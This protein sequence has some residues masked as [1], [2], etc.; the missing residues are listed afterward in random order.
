MGMMYTAGID[1]GSAFSKAVIIAGQEMI[2]SHMIPS[3]GNYGLSAEKVIR[4]A[5]DSA[6]LSRD[7]IRY[8]AATG[9]G[10]RSVPF[11]DRVVSDITCNGKAMS[12][13]FPSVRTV[14]DIGDLFSKAFRMDQSG[15][16]ANFVMS[17]KCAGG[18]AKILH[19]ISRVLQVKQDEIG[20]LSLKSRNRIEFNAGCA[21]FM[22]TEAVSRIAEGTS[23]EDLLAGVHHA[24]GSQVH[25]LALRAGVEEDYAL[26]GGGAR[27]LGLVKAV[28]EVSG[29]EVTVPEKP[30]L[31]AAFGAALIAAKSVRRG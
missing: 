17:G 31:M 30:Q 8:L 13:F 12:F 19:V 25:S 6:K 18:C 28:E 21:V 15:G 2:S 14:V 22:E 27:D 7:D 29:L 24:L 4:E 26:V 5:L 20:R 3:G 16:I 11:Q 23:K 9:Y 1:I 10:A